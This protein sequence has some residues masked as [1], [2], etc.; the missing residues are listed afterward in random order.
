V[1]AGWAWGSSD[2][3]FNY[4]A[5]LTGTANG[6]PGDNPILPGDTYPFSIRSA[7]AP[8]LSYGITQDVKLDYSDSGY[9][10]VQA[11]MVQTPEPGAAMQGGAAVLLL[12][13][14]WRRR[15]SKSRAGAARFR[16]A[17]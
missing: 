3:P 14:L 17:S 4:V 8:A 9:L 13:P 5:F 12:L 16:T 15:C 1:P 2:V 10:P 11:P 7:Y 6:A